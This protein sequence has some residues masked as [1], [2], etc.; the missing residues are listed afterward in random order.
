MTLLPPGVPAGEVRPLN[1]QVAARI[2]S[3]GRITKDSI[4]VT[5]IRSPVYRKEIMTMIA[6]W[7]FEPATLSPD[8]C[9]VPGTAVLTFRS[10]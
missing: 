1:V 9:S 10:R 2:D 6:G 4:N 3:I 5:G 8:R 7:Q